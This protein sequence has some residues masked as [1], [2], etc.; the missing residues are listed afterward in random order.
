VHYEY[1]V[2]SVKRR[3]HLK[4]QGLQLGSGFDICL[5]YSR[6]LTLSGEVIGLNED[7]DLTP[8]LAR[9]LEINRELVDG[10]L[11][12][13]EEK[14]SHYRRHHK[15]EC[16]WKSQVMTYKFLTFVYDQ[17]RDPD[18]LAQSLL[19]FEKDSRVQEL[20]LANYEVFKSAYI[21]LAAVSGSEAATWWYIFWVSE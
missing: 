11:F 20:M 14:I 12:T 5:K 8:S 3:G 15:N 17:P 19:E 7:C 10:S 18:G 4:W 21:R 1:A 9:F 13:V 16:L 6:S 2:L